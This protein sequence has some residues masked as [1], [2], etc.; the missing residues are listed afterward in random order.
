M[1]ATLHHL[2]PPSPPLAGF[3]R[4]GHTGQIKLE[5][6]HA[7]GRFPYRRVVFEAAHLPKQLGFLK[8]LKATGCEV[9]LDPNF[10]EMATEG[11]FQ[12]AVA[13]LGWANPA[14]PWGPDDFG[15]GR[16]VNLG[17]LVAEF[18][19]QHDV[20]VVLAPTH[21]LEAAGDR[22]RSVDLSFCEI[23]RHELDRLGSQEIAIDYQLI[24]TYSVLREERQRRE[25]IAGIDDLP[26]DNVWLRISG[27]GASATGV[28]TRHLIE[29]TSDLH[30]LGRPFVADCAG[31]LAALAALAFGAVSGICHGVGQK[32]DFRANDW[33]RPTAGGGSG[34]RIYIPELDR[35]FS[36]EQVN[37]IFAARG[38]RPRFGCNDSNCCPHGID[39]MVENPHAHF[40]TQ[41][42]RQLDDLSAVPDARRAEHYLLHHVEPAVRSARLGARLKIADDDTR[43]LVDDA[44]KR[45]VRLRDALD[46][47]DSQDG[48]DTRSPAVPFRGGGGAIAAV[49]GR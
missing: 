25:L 36:E 41:R 34:R 19:V 11:R 16:N 32:E 38:G 26:V 9:V 37:A 2:H 12:S 20:N 48:I 47:L 21:L 40:I 43:R 24:T 10:A 5:A 4:V 6:L 14:R 44:R 39:D 45:L 7:A 30:R 18:A 22:W 28:G 42:S 15:P 49:L 31:G 29:A 3:L 27:F 35:H 17:R 46:D 13:R 8:V 1:A 33:R 23:L